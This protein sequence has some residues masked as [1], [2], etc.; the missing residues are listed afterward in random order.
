ML[1][2][3]TQSD[4]WALFV[5]VAT[6]IVTLNLALFAGLGLVVYILLR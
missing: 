6:V 4:S 2:R 3:R 1:K 5:L